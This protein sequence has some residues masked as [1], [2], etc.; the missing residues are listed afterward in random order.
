[1]PTTLGGGEAADRRMWPANAADY[2]LLEEIGDGASAIVYRAICIPFNETVAIKSLDLEKCNSNMDDIRREAQLM[3]LVHHPNLVRAYC[4]FVK[5]QYLWVVMPFMAGGS[6]LHIMKS[7]FPDGFDE[8]V[9]ASILKETLKALEYLHRHGHIHRDVKAGNILIDSGGAVKLADFGVSAAM[10]EMGDRQRARNTFVGTPCW[11]APEV[12]EQLHGYDFKAD[13]WSFGITA[14]ELAHGHAPFSKFPPMKVLLM[15]LQNAPPGLDL[16]RDKRFSKAF[17]EMIAMCLVKDPSKR[18]SAEKLLKHSFFKHAKPADFVARAILVGLPPLGERVSALKDKDAAR[19]AAKKMP[20][21]E[22]EAQS[23][24][25]YKR[26]VSSWNF[27]VDDLKAQAALLKDDDETEATPRIPEDEAVRRGGG[28]GGSAWGPDGGAPHGEERGPP[29]ALPPAFLLPS[30]EPPHAALPTVIE[31]SVSP[32]LPPV[33]SAD[34]LSEAIERA[35]AKGKSGPLLSQPLQ[36]APSAKG[37]DHKAQPGP[38]GRKE[39]MHRGRFEVYEGDQDD[40]AE[41]KLERSQDRSRRDREARGLEEDKQPER[42]FGAHDRDRSKSGP[43]MVERGVIVGSALVGA[44]AAAALGPVKSMGRLSEEERERERE[45]EHRKAGPAEPAPPGRPPPE[46]RDRR[47]FSAPLNEKG[48]PSVAAKDVGP[49]DAKG[50][51]PSSAQRKGRF[52]VTTGN[53]VPGESSH[54]SKKGAAGSQPGTPSSAHAPGGGGGTVVPL[55][56][57]VPHLQSLMKLAAEQQDVV[58]NLMNSLTPSDVHAG[59]KGSFSRL[60]SVSSELAA[61]APSERERELLLQVA[62]LQ[63]RVVFMGE[64]MQALKQRNVQLERQLNV[65]FNKEEE[66]RIRKEEAA[67]DDR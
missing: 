54:H 53:D 62:D 50:V 8:P 25:E 6:C 35:A 21:S 44:A 18:P 42:T 9:I 26:G 28:A 13:I 60:S 30:F 38:Q 36:K 23:Q 5:E 29:S 49:A 2:E 20:T 34:G 32:P 57:L 16:E 39:P 52:S 10:Y 55:A 17:K 63:G 3:S 56:A 7:H 40:T 15:T 45:R 1:M 11:M 37:P 43:L 33:K 31:A 46:E 65:F 27:N 66:E 67:K 61:E 12:M 64:E 19:L 47:A 4:S 59:S 22:Q 51:P 24:V 58:F 41:E 48:A 14:L